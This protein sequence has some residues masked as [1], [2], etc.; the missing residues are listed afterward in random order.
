[1]AIFNSFLLV[2]QR[3]SALSTANHVIISGPT[4]YNYVVIFSI[5]FQLGFWCL[6]L[7]KTWHS[8]QTLAQKKKN[9]S[10]AKTTA[11]LSLCEMTHQKLSTFLGNEMSIFD[12]QRTEKQ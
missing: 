4:S 9:F 6:L 12:G 7:A 1:M 2:H 8:D 3:V 5:S 11:P 10:C